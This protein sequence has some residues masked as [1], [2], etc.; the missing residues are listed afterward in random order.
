MSKGAEHDPE[1]RLLLDDFERRSSRAPV[2]SSSHGDAAPAQSALV[3]SD[4][5]L[6]LLVEDFGPRPSAWHA[7][8]LPA[9]GP[10]IKAAPT[11]E[12]APLRVLLEDYPERI[13]DRGATPNQRAPQAVDDTPLALLLEDF[14]P[15][16]R[17]LSALSETRPRRPAPDDNIPPPALLIDW[18][19]ELSTTDERSARL[20]SAAIHLVGIVFLLLQP[21]FD[22]RDELTE[23]DLQ[24]NDYTEIAL[25]APSA[26]ELRELLPDQTQ[27]PGQSRVFQGLDER[28]KPATTPVQ[29]A[30]PPLLVETP[31]PP[32]PL[33]VPE[34]ELE[35]EPE[36]AQSLTPP[37][38]PPEEEPEPEADIAALSP[39][40][41]EFRRGNEIAETR[42]SNELPMP[43]APRR[44]PEK[45]KLQLEDPKA[46]MPGRA[47]GAQI[48]SFKIN[49]R[50]DEV[51][52]GAIRQ[53]GESSG[54]PQAIGEGVGASGG[55]SSGLLQPS[56]D[57]VGSG[58]QLLSDPK[59]VDFRPYLTMVLNA[60]RRNWYAVIPESARLG[61]NRGRVAIQFAVAPDGTVP[62]LVIANSSGTHTLDR[63]AV[64]G[65][66]ASL[67]LP[68]LPAEFT[69]NEI[70]LQLVFLY[71]SRFGR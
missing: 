62:K 58:L 24:K 18:N 47:G 15:A 13:R 57:N 21:H 6:H 42:R 59:G 38:E 11:E 19:N 33:E 45:P 71:N 12:V 10:R 50:P 30:S 66:S 48:G 60:V 31:A 63:A 2:R 68:P 51:I 36:T 65:I 56:I 4:Q 5:P 27:G 40:P 32:Q 20:G 23:N 55:G 64:A 25:I 26:A 70:R 69:G 61:M 37:P 29:S 46:A 7:A 3:R 35:P 28:P 53:M 39:A 17:S 44:R 67:P 49:A 9:A 16:A 52:A 22:P 43:R 14:D 8:D 54:G 1:L 41:G 34:P